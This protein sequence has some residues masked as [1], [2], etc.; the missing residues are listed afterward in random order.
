MGLPMQLPNLQWDKLRN[1]QKKNS[2]MACTSLVEEERDLSE[3][4]VEQ[5]GQRGQSIRAD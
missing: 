1:L 4:V 5:A 2:Q 3:A